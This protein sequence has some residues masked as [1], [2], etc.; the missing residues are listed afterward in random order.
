MNKIYCSNCGTLIPKNSN[1]CF[2]CG[3]AQHGTESAVYRAQNPTAD[4]PTVP[5][6][7]VIN[8][9]LYSPRPEADSLEYIKRRHLSPQAVISFFIN[10]LFKTSI[11]LPLLLVGLV[12]IPAIFSILLVGYMVILYLIAGGIY[13]SFRYEID[14]NGFKKEYGIIHKQQVSIPYGQIQNVNIN[15]SLVDRILGLSK[16]SIETAGNVSSEPKGITGG[17][18]SSAEG[19]LPGVALSDAKKIHDLLLY[20]AER[21]S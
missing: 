5:S 16:I 2:N 6:P 15:R 21:A 10:Y 12:F 7:E 1:Y 9:K 4:R 20:N 14:K 11:L 19:Y 8:E 13:Q 17:T 3:A 18:A